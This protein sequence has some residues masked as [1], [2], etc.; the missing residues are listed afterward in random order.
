M[1]DMYVDFARVL[2]VLDRGT[3]G[4][5]QVSDELGSTLDLLHKASKGGHAEAEFLLFEHSADVTAQDKL[6]VY[7]VTPCIWEK[8]C[9]L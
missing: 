6:R 8:T 4:E 1:R 3:D 5:A 9:E 2:Q 7:S